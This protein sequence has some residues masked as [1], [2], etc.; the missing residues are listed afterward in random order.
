MKVQA[1]NNKA[2]KKQTSIVQKLKKDWL[3]YLLL[4]PALLITLVFC[5]FPLPGI[6]ITFQEYDIFLGPIHSPW[7]GFDN[8]KAI[9]E[10]PD[11]TKALSNTVVLFFIS[12]IV[13]FPVPI[14]LALLLNEVKLKLFKR[15]VQT[16]TYLPH[17]LSWISV[18]GIAYTMYSMYGPINDMR[19]SM[20]G[21][22]AERI[23]FMAKQG[24]FIPNILMLSL[25]KEMGWGTIIYLA[26][27]SGINPEL[28]EAAGIDGA[29]KFQQAMRITIPG[30]MPTAMI[31]L[32]LSMSGLLNSNFE[33]VFGLQN[34]FIDY[35]VLSTLVYKFGIQQAHYS[36]ATAVGFI[37]GVV[38]FVLLI[39]VNFITKKISS[40]S[41]W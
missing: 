24:F 12:L 1:A 2:V 27:I 21:S 37:Q 11:I 18:I 8:I 32:I 7:I 34:S 9:F 31:L 13:G 4:L 23:L 33:L 26:A 6:L 35:D 17:F 22:D 10:L 19:V 40:I 20:L 29:G 3:I 36:L 5:Y 16:L 15:T 25:W 28:Y 41:I 30:I 39:V 38:A 14:I